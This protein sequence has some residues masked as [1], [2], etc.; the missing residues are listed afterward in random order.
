MKISDINYI[1]STDAIDKIISAIVSGL[2]DFNDT[3][4]LKLEIMFKIRK[5]N[6]QIYFDNEFKQ[7]F[8]LINS[9]KI[10]KNISVNKKIDSKNIQKDGFRSIAI[11]NKSIYEVAK[12]LN[13]TT[14]RLI[15]I[16]IRKNNKYLNVNGDTLINE[17]I[18]E[19]LQDFVKMKF[20]REKNK[21]KMKGRREK[22]EKLESFNSKKMDQK[23]KPSLGRPGNYAKLIYIRT[24]T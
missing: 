1:N 9:K 11:K 10:S 24:K 17:E 22:I 14:E 3:N 18:L 4:E 20:E 23:F 21:K 15:S 13:Q 6:L 8:K 19:C 7:N 16:I 12:M 5:L 2:I